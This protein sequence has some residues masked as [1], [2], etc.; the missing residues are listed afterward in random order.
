MKVRKVKS[1]FRYFF[2]LLLFLVLW[3][4]TTVSSTAVTLEECI[5]TALDN[6]PDIQAG[7]ARIQAAKSMIRQARSA[8][9]PRLY[10]SGTYSMTDNPPQAF[11]MELNQKDL[12]M[13][14]PSF[15]PNDPDAT[16]NLRFSVGLHYR[17]Y[18]GGINVLNIHMAKEEK[19][20]KDF[21]LAA[22]QNELI[23]QV[24]RGYYGVLQAQAFVTVQEESVRSLEENLRVAKAR[25][26]AGSA[27]KTDVL[28]LDVKLA[29]AREDLI[30]AQNSVRLAI[31]SLNTAIG[32]DLVALNGIPVPLQE[33]LEEEPIRLDYAAIEN[34]PE[35]KAAKKMSEILSKVYE[36]ATRER[37]PTVSA[38]GSYDV[39]S[40]DASDFENSYLVGVMA[41]WEFFDGYQRSNKA[42][43]AKADW[44]AAK[45]EEEKATNNL[46]LDLHQSFL[47]AS[48]AWQRLE[49]TKKSV[50]N[51]KEALRITGE[52]YKEGA[53]DI[54]ILLTAQVGLTAQKTRN[55]A[56]YY[57]YLTALSNFERASGQAVKKYVP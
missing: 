19:I 24:T 45:R 17:L 48:E 1:P 31:A 29:Q 36:K 38:F 46:R 34:R 22:V 47:K 51:A 25:F 57:D 56:A 50:E 40:G 7:M 23:H 30:L 15:D 8:Y 52:Q 2:I 33:E 10:V 44:R 18:N 37:Y 26:Q 21:Q 43:T 49:V 12:D 14:D 11:M 32:K 28:N 5:R 55:V 16:D 4:G 20:A 41:K 27:V 9:Y 53:A 6:N 54:T 35:L 39:D 3:T 13:R 42:Q